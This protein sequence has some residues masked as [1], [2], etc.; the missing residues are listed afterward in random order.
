[1]NTPVESDKS[2]NLNESVQQSEPPRR[3]Y[4][5]RRDKVDT[6]DLKKSFTPQQL[7]NLPPKIDLRNQ[8]P[9]IYDQGNLGSCTA[10]AIGFG[11]QFDAMKQ[12]NKDKLAPSR[13]FIYYNERVLEGTVD[14]DSGAE[15]RD[16]IKTVNKQG[17]CDEIQ[18]PYDIKKFAIKPPQHCYDVAKN[19]RAL[20]YQSL[21]QDQNHLEAC[22]AQG[23]PIEFG[24]DV[25]E[26]FESDAVEKTGKVPMPKKGEKLL[27]GH[28][29]A[30]VGYDRPTRTFIVRNSW[31]TTWGDGGYCYFPYDYVLSKKMSSD[32]WVIQSI[33]K[34]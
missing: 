24:F 29:V 15:I 11:V 27:G 6:R 28:A 3:V 9:S 32:F 25:Y 30:I 7:T 10:N 33:T 31:G 17:V 8:C 5:W 26:S 4:G 13:L 2:I 21:L 23:F 12:G 18:W 16:G 22:L 20:R 19:H 1:M 34:D 14:Q